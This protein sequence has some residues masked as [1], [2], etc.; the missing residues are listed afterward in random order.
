[1]TPRLS[2]GPWS[3][4]AIG[5][6]HCFIFPV[7]G[8]KNMDDDF[9][10]YLDS[11]TLGFIRQKAR[12]LA[13]RYGFQSHEAE[14]IQQS[15]ILD[16]LERLARFNPHRGV[17][18]NFTRF[19]VKRAVATLIE[20]RQCSSR[21][22]DVCQISLDSPTY[23][24]D[25][26][27]SGFA[28]VISDDACR[29]R[30]ARSLNVPEQS[31]ALKIDVDRAIASLR[32][33]LRRICFLLVVLDRVAQVANVAGVS[34]ATLHRRMRMI[35]SAFVEMH[36]SDYVPGTGAKCVEGVPRSSTHRPDLPRREAESGSGH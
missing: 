27:A 4:L 26:G 33:E 3:T 8:R 20:T 34:R 5:R 14:D 11:E 25:A 28:D 2:G 1:M 23:K 13:G 7:V 17:R 35:R 21:G 16:C 30:T 19:V 9:E 31:M 32:P 22:F 36:I 6:I 12:Q 10:R 29:S 18:T 24:N 15:L